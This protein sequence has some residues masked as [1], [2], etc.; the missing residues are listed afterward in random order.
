MHYIIV[1]QALFQVQI[2]L[3]LINIMDISRPEMASVIGAEASVFYV[4]L[5]VEFLLE[6]VT[7]LKITRKT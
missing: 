3:Q 5:S 4:E 6:N 2:R 7:G 1:V